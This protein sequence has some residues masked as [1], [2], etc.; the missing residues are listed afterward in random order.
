MSL[1]THS[2]GARCQ[3]V[4]APGP[5][6]SDVR[7]IPM[8]KLSEEDFAKEYQKAWDASQYLATAYFWA[9]EQQKKSLTEAM[10][11]C[12]AEADSELESPIP[13]GQFSPRRVYFHATEQEREAIRDLEIEASIYKRLLEQKKNE[14]KYLELNRT[15]PPAGGDTKIN[16][17]SQGNY[18][19]NSLYSLAYKAIVLIACLIIIKNAI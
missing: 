1:T 4:P 6:N 16:E 17:E 3:A 10:N 5:L 13:A 11:R 19:L 14:L 15:V 2:R 8:S 9:I 18:F 12:I 7:G